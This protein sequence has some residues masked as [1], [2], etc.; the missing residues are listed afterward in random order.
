MASNYSRKS[1][2]SDS[3]NIPRRIARG[4]ETVSPRPQRRTPNVVPQSPNPRPSRTGAAARAGSQAFASRIYPANDERIERMQTRYDRYVRRILIGVGIVVAVVA[5]Y[6]V[7]W[8]AGAFPVTSVT[9]N[10]AEHLTA[11]EVAD[12][13][14]VPSDTTLLRVDTGEI[15]SRLE[16]NA[17]V[18]SAGVTKILPGTLR[19][20]ITEREIEAV[21]QVTSQDGSTLENWA[22]ARDG[23]WLMK[24]PAQDSDEGSAVNQAV[25]DDASSAL[26]ITGVP[27]G[28]TPSA[29]SV[30]EDEIVNNA[31][32]IISGLS[33]ELSSRVKSVEAGSTTM[34]TLTLDD[35]IQIAFGDG[36]DVRDKERVVLQLLEEHAGEIAYIN[37]SSPSRPTWRSL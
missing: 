36:D 21:V 28:L 3:R 16:N 23:V 17:W 2:S 9:V 24:I 35:G 27:Y 4:P 30:C 26:Q 29:G 34:A 15:V 10:G 18:E 19:L 14:E 20:D 8:F 31:L 25:Y 32:D 7:L 33:D 1:V 6:A 12:I 5:L 13:A 11:Q 37:V 22:I